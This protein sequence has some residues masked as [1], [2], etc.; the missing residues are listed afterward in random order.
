MLWGICRTLFWRTCGT[1]IFIIQCARYTKEGRP[2]ISVRELQKELQTELASFITIK[3]KHICASKW[4]KSTLLKLP[5]KIME[6][7]FHS[8]L[9]IATKFDDELYINGMLGYKLLVI[10]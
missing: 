3:T 10:L 6:F 4:I 7:K 2:F 9:Q 8:L 5:S 1:L